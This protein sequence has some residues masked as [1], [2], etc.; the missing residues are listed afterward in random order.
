MSSVVGSGG[1]SLVGHPAA[2][3]P[4]VTQG[5]PVGSGLRK[6]TWV[7]GHRKERV[8]G[9]GYKRVDPTLGSL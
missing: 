4:Q 3:Q 7:I 8:G 6:P 9:F 2:V 5:R 1:W